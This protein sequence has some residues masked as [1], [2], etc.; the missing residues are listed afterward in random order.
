MI[1]LIDNYDSFVYNLARY[2]EILGCE[3]KVI[4]ND[5]IT[6]KQIEQLNPSSI[7]ISP[8]PCAPAEAGISKKVIEV[9][10]KDIPILGVCLGHQAIG[11][12]FGATVCRALRPMHGMS[13]TI[14]FKPKGIFANFVSPME[15]ARYHSLIVSNQ[16]FPDCLEITAFSE[17]NE[18]MAI[19]HR[20]YPVY[21]VQF[22]PESI[23]TKHG[24]ALIEHFLLIT[25]QRKNSEKTKKS[26]FQYP[27]LN[28]VMKVKN[29]I[30]LSPG[31]VG[32]D[33]IMT[34][35]EKLAN[36]DKDNS[37]IIHMGDCSER[38]SDATNEISQQKI[39]HMLFVEGL[40]KSLLKRPVITIGRLAG[41]YAK[42]RSNLTEKYKDEE[43]NSYYGDM[44]NS[45]H[46]DK[47]ARL[48]QAERMLQAYTASQKIICNI[49]SNCLY[50]SHEALLLEYE[51]SLI[52][53]IDKVFYSSSA[54]YL[55]LGMR[56]IGSSPH[57]QLL[58]RIS[59]PVA[60]KIASTTSLDT[61]REAIEEINPCNEPGKLTLITR[62]GVNNVKDFLPSLINLVTDNGYNVIWMCDPM[63]GNTKVD[64]NGMK[65][66]LVRVIQQEII[67]TINILNIYNQNLS[68]LHLETSYENEINE[69][70][71]DVSELTR[72]RDY[73]SALDPRLNRYQAALCFYRLSEI[74]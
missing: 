53:H 29:I 12:V 48:P 63:H 16:N 4:R 70:I 3:K 22:H 17:E 57:R 45:E 37:F 11:E 50:T 28:S 14:T 2:F 58:A 9:F 36:V 32:L 40:L 72:D 38:L 64:E 25:G 27:D 6:I 41:Q 74:L 19:Q 54:H 33:S 44:I 49:G 73:R 21:G 55:W 10:H 7:V 20:E 56:N 35:K 8:G 46:P 26:V 59:N 13:S 34:L 24:L 52:R 71:G 65:F 61:I 47:N 66:R 60:M 31:L 18:I 39:N 43:I 68:G 69:C 30:S 62:L 23:L 1:L 67:E 15:V 5:H 51:E 42:P